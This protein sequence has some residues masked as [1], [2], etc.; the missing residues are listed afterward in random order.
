[1][2]VFISYQHNSQAIADE[3][4]NAL[5]ESGIHCWYAPHIQYGD[6]AKR[7]TEAI[8]L[9]KV[10]IPIMNEDAANS[11]HV[12]NEVEI[13]YKRYIAKDVT[14]IPFKLDQA[15]L[16]GDF[17]YYFSRMQWVDASQNLSEAIATLVLR[18]KE[19]LRPALPEQNNETAIIPSQNVGNRYF[20]GT[21]AK[22][23]RR[24]SNED[25]IVGKYEE[26]IWDK[27]LEGKTD[28]TL[29]DLNVLSLAGCIDRINRPEINHII[30]L[31]YCKEIL[32]RG[33][34]QVDDQPIEFYQVEF[35]DVDFA[36][37]LAEC[38]EKSGVEKIDVVCASM[39]FMDFK[40][41]YRVM[42]TIKRF[43][44][45][46]AVML[47]RDIDDGAVFA[48]PDKNGIFEKYQTYYK[49]NEYSGYRFTGR[50]IYSWLQ[51]VGAKEITLE[52]YGLSTANMTES[53]KATLFECWFGFMPTDMKRMLKEKDPK[54]EKA[55]EFL[56]YHYEH[57]SEIEEAY[58]SEEFIFSAG[59]VIYSVRF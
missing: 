38:L 14:I 13:A 55:I 54:H 53:E 40:N 30:G 2:E 15:P 24:L 7:I 26:P 43:L 50:M 22:E 8:K 11:E 51:K 9:C 42:K 21:D 29:L 37:S 56:D 31:T 34:I 46:G 23:S 20:T 27:L 49:Y 59:Y 35:D 28:L 5:E 44:S 12:L 16:S 25:M 17:E 1:M 36:D 18:V 6:Y 19:I 39:S 3:I 10:F 58:D 41:P 45:K 48:Y 47:V 33:N 4:Y 57:F 52:K 32:E